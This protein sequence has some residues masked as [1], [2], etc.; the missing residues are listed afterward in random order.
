[1]ILDI[2]FSWTAQTQ[3]ITRTLKTLRALAK[4][5]PTSFFSTMMDTAAVGGLGA[6]DIYM[7]IITIP[8]YAGIPSAANPIAPLN[9]F[10]KAAP[11]A[12]VP[13]FD[14]FGLDPTSTNITIANPMPVLTG[15]QTVPLLVTIPKGVK[16]A[17]GWPV[18]IFGHG[19]TR[20]RMDLLA[21][22]D[23]FAAAGY[24]AV[25]M[26]FPMHG[27]SPDA[28]PQY[29]PFWIENTPFAPVANERTFN[30]DYINNTTGA[31]GPDGLI[32]PSGAHAVSAGLSNMLVGRDLIRQ[33]ETD[34]SVLAISIASM[35]FDGDSV[36]DTDG[37]N[38][39]YAGQS[40]GGIHGTV[41]TAIEPLVTRSFLS[42]P[43]GSIARFAEASAS[44]GP[45]IRAGLASKGVY[46]GTAD[47]ESFFLVWQTVLD[48]AD[49]INWAA[50]AAAHT[51]IL[52]HE[53]I[54]DQVIPNFVPTS[55]LAGTEPLIKV[56][57]LTAYS[58]TQQSANGLRAA[59]RFV[60]P[61]S[62]GSWL[63]PSSSP[64]AFLEMQKQA[65]TFIGSF[66]GAVVVSNSSTMVPVVQVQSQSIVDLTEKKSSN[67][68]KEKKKRGTVNSRM[69]TNWL[70]KNNRS[71][72]PERFE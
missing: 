71:D 53:V 38:I 19:I 37:S 45:V 63:D 15:M 12:Y 32:D 22:A 41:F 60:P 13:P 55:P 28:T 56:M 51:P 1:L 6:A 31:P 44:F 68:V 40:W 20:S 39:A 66:G 16:P 54:N 69:T 46:P 23:S 67:T 48:S 10:W 49:P 58:T 61:A 57:G 5:A 62:H 52:L 14:Q 43:G 8:Y 64:A 65:A 36:P 3:S 21:I 70:E 33:G 24:V 17:N 26:D 42:V 47:Y 35:D 7:G 50:A 59:G 72:Q 25:A 27:V 4:P 2:V 30:V 29:A 9:T 34:L 11:G 18:V